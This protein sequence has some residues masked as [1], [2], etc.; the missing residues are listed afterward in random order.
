MHLCT[1]ES[2][3]QLVYLV[4]ISLCLT[5]PP[6]PLCAFT[7]ITSRS[8]PFLKTEHSQILWLVSHL[9]I[10][11]APHVQPHRARIALKT[12]VNRLRFGNSHRQLRKDH[13]VYRCFPLPHSIR[14]P[15]HSFLAHLCFHSILV[16]DI[17]SA[18]NTPTPGLV[19]RKAIRPSSPLPFHFVLRACEAMQPTS[20]SFYSCVYRFDL[21]T[22]PALALANAALAITHTCHRSYSPSFIL[23]IVHHRHRQHRRIIASHA[24]RVLVNSRT[25]PRTSLYPLPPYFPNSHIGLLPTLHRDRSLRHCGRPMVWRHGFCWQ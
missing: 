23:A 20:C 9:A 24:S 3:C 19:E 13:P 22:S 7:F 4:F 15:F 18:I 2:T 21:T 8:S 1:S 12:L 5:S 11:V 14:I 17:P 10:P 25:Q 6:C 16:I